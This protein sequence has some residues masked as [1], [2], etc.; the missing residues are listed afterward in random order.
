MSNSKF[1]INKMKMEVPLPIMLGGYGKREKPAISIHDDLYVNCFLVHSDSINLAILSCDLLGIYDGNYEKIVEKIMEKV[2]LE[3]FK[4]LLSCVHSH[5]APIINNNPKYSLNKDKLM[6]SLVNTSVNLIN[7]SYDNLKEQKLSFT[8]SYYNGVGKNRR[9]KDLEINTI[10]RTISLDKEKSVVVNYN[11]HPTLLS[12]K[13][14][15]VSKDYQG[16]CLEYLCE[17]YGYKSMF[18]QGACGDV[19]TRFTRTS[20]SF[21][22]VY[23]LGRLLGEQTFNQIKD[24]TFEAIENVTFN[25]YIFNLPMKEYH[26]ENYY[27][28]EIKKFSNLINSNQNTNHGELRLLETTLQGIK[29]EYLMSLNKN[30]EPLLIP[31]AIL[32][33]NNHA[34]VFLP[35][36]LFSKLD[37]EICKRSPYVSTYIIGYCFNCLGYLADKE[38]YKEGGYEVLSSIYA[39]GAGEILVDKIISLLKNQKGEY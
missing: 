8:E 24:T 11:C 36:E 27:K 22:E 13:N 4:V 28:E 12:Y 30:Y 10:L 34:L 7:T 18:L 5:S 31:C 37:D 39:N 17:A 2:H 20:Q 1:S 23:R 25:E 35:F 33:L 3:N 29:K 16:A 14:N 9:S 26:H 32:T 38:S 19:S 6:N 21:E 15:E